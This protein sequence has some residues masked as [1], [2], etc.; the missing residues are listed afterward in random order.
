MLPGVHIVNQD[1]Q[2]FWINALQHHPGAVSL[3]EAGEHG[4]EVRRA[5]SQ[6]HLSSETLQLMMIDQ[7]LT[8]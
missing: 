5:G 3:S 2:S 7:D 4:V 1:V 8:L 6:H